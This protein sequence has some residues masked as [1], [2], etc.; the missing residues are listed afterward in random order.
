ML[1][2]AK[3]KTV[4]GGCFAFAPLV[5]P[6]LFC[7]RTSQLGESACH[8]PFSYRFILLE[9]AAAGLPGNYYLVTQNPLKI[10]HVSQVARTSALPGWPFLLAGTA[11][12]ARVLIQ[13][14]QVKT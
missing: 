9:T 4:D 14:P 8:M 3:G 2:F 1:Y 5:G 7:Q 11:F 10:E 6:N 12:F 13:H